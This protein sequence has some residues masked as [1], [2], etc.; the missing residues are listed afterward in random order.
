[1]EVSEFGATPGTSTSPSAVAKFDYVFSD[2]MTFTDHR[3]KRTRLWIKEEVDVP[4]AEAFM[5]M[6][7]EKTL[8]VLNDE[9]ID[10]Y[11]NPTFLPAVIAK[12]YDK[13]WT[14]ARMERVIDAAVK[15]GIAI[16]INAAYRLPSAAFIKL[17]KGKGA[18]FSFGTN[19]TDAKLG[20][21]E[22]CVEMVRACGL[23]PE[24]MCQPKPDGKK[25]VQVRG[26]KHKQ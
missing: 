18:K 5:E 7:V 24:D 22:Y 2:A 26:F 19:N 1:M 11:V 23:T 13:L 9:P 6:L 8:G 3:G 21:L 16:E 4:D 10:I 25:P 14:Q 12:D 20:R 17:A 15:N